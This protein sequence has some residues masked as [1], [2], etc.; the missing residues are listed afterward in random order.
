MVTSAPV[1]HIGARLRLFLDAYGLAD[2]RAIPARAA[3]V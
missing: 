1:P 3:A 2:R